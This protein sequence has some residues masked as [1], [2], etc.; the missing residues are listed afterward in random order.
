M[1]KIWNVILSVIMLALCTVPCYATQS[2]TVRVAVIDYP[3]F[4]NTEKD[5]SFYG[6]AYEYL[7]DIQ[8][9]TDW[10]YDF[11]EMSFS[12]A[13]DA[14]AKGEIDLVAGTQYS[15][16]RA[17]KW[18]YSNES[19]SEGGTIL[20]TTLDNN[21]YAYND[22]ASYDG[23]RIA[24][25]RGTVRIEQVSQKLAEY[26][27]SATFVEYDSDELSKEALN[28]GEVDAIMMSNIRSEAAYKII[29]RINRTPLYFCLNKNRP[30]LKTTLDAAVESIHLENPYY[31]IQLDEKY[32]GDIRV[33]TSFSEAE[34][35]YMKSVGNITVAISTDMEPIEYYDEASG[36]YCG[37][38]PDT[39]TAITEKTGLSFTYVPRK[40]IDTLNTQLENGDVQLVASVVSLTNVSDYLE[41]TDSD[42]FY[43][44]GLT[45][46]T[47]NMDSVDSDLDG[48]MVLKD[49][50]PFFE[51]AAQRNGY[52][53][54]SY[55][56]SFDACL[57]DVLNG[58]A[59]YTLIPSNS[60]GIFLSHD[61]YSVLKS[62]FLTDTTYKY[63]FGVSNYASPMLL[64]II[65]K[66][67]ATITDDQRVQLMVD[68]ISSASN[69][70]VTI[71]DFIFSHRVEII[72]TVFIL[73]L[74]IFLLVIWN[75][76]R[77]NRLNQQLR[78][79]AER[80]DQAS[81]AKSEFLSNMS[82]DIRTPMV[83]ILSLTELSLEE[84]DQPKQLQEDLSKIKTSGQFL[85]G[86]LNDVLDMSRIESGKMNLHP[87]VYTHAAFVGY[88]ESISVPLCKQRGVQFDWDKGNT[89][90][91]VYVDI[92]RFNQI[93]YNILSNAIKYT[94]EGGRVSMWVKNNH[95]D[96]GVLYCD[97]IIQDTGIGMSKEF[98]KKL[99]VPFERAESA[100][101]YSG[102]GLGLSITKQI[103]DLMHGT[104]HI[105][106]ELGK[107]TTV[108]L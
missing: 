58:K 27:V 18:L 68:N 107:G 14:L 3:N 94:P 97:F 1:R 59:D 42:S 41:I 100:S 64:S 76:K 16:E 31:E 36:T 38:I 49:G 40:D 17:S 80:A 106:S 2:E 7:M 35:E 83:A 47:K 85:L 6:Y 66:S 101:A 95:I 37:L 54:I 103:V 72:F 44:N 26:G 70:N 51:W 88:M 62:F 61:K 5:G 86:L 8:K 33:Q 96:N 87:S 34:R 12:D 20:C 71:Q 60:A 56:D 10:N 45:L 55:V 77:L 102:T 89:N 28:S 65:N 32:Y 53:N 11:V 48:S 22:Y 93:F 98:Q 50:Y 69:R 30:E 29:A 43:D 15:E 52:S 4:L 24:A 79:E 82:H 81:R 9:Y 91:D 46:V 75:A 57:D 63:G 92:T 67:L 19:M 21:E 74:I 73:I 78:T 90:F 25:L 39:L 13:S 105:D 104:I 99:F 84:L 23:I 108:T